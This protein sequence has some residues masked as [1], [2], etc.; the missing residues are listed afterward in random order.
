MDVVGNIL[1][2]A[3][4]KNDL[5]RV[6]YSEKYDEVLN[7]ITSK[8]NAMLNRMPEVEKVSGTIQLRTQGVVKKILYKY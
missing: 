5:K 2:G 1:G 6:A 7:T 3:K 4:A 8:V